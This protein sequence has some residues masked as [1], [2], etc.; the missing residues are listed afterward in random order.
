MTLFQHGNSGVDVM[1]LFNIVHILKLL[2][3][4]NI[5]SYN[6]FASYIYINV[7]KFSLKLKLSLS[8]SKYIT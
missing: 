3:F 7:N 2:L 8:T 5:L 1:F 4:E 6:F